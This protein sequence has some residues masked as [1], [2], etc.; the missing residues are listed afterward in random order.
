MDW[1]D[2]IFGVRYVCALNVD[3]SICAYGYAIFI[4]QKC[5]T[6][7]SRIITQEINLFQ[8]PAIHEEAVSMIILVIPFF[9]VTASQEKAFLNPVDSCPY[10]NTLQCVAMFE[11]IGTG[12]NTAIRNIGEFQLFTSVKSRI[13]D[14]FDIRRNIERFQTFAVCE[15]SRAYA[16]HGVRNIYF[17]KIYAAEESVFT[18]GLQCGRKIY[19]LQSFELIERVLSNHIHALGKNQTR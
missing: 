5:V 4:H 14:C 3:K 19:L 12:L 10:D 18:N 1:I 11:H 6:G 15:S 16:R 13:S 9:D 8:I 7:N 17:Q 2:K